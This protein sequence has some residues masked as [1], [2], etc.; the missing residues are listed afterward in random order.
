[1]PEESTTFDLAEATRLSFAAANRRDWDTVM[2][3]FSHDAGQAQDLQDFE[4]RTAIRGLLEDGVGTYHAVEI[5]TED[6]L[7]LGG[8]VGFVIAC[9]EGQLAESTAHLRVRCGAVY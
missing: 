9:M 2:G 3:F 1:M 6:I 5:E 8:G 7:D 4:G